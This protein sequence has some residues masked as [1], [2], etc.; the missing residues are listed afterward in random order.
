LTASRIRGVEALRHRAFVILL[1]NRLE[2]RIAVGRNCLDNVN[3]ASPL[4]VLA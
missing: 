1:H 4:D 3:P 2:Q